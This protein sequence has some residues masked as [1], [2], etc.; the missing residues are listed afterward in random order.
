VQLL[1]SVADAR[2]AYSAVAGGAV[3][4]DAKEPTEGP[5][6]AV[7]PDVL[8]E[9]VDAVAGACPLSVAIGDAPAADGDSGDSGDGVGADDLVFARAREAAQAGADYVK[10]GFAGT[11]SAAR[12]TRLTAAAVR[13]ARA[14]SAA[15]RVIAV[16]YAD[17]AVVG[18]VPPA[19]IV[20]VA[21]GA[22]AA[23]VLLDTAD[24][25][26]GGLFDVM[27]VRDVAAW[28][29]D[30]ERA[31]LIPAIAGKLDD[32]GVATARLLGAHVAGVRGAACLG[33]RDGR[34]VVA[35]VR[36]LADAA[37]G[38]AALPIDEWFAVARR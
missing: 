32:R 12:A 5:L 21:T 22:G 19:E 1:I 9:I 27:S 4:V 7:L 3:I 15:T 31:G 25:R 34:V 26:G 28:V 37:A 18:S 35:R 24:K 30:A 36:A 16:A 38:L 10:L 2:E 6:G 20:G 33:G 23:G 13:G 14:A 29:R 8:R 11:R 17:A